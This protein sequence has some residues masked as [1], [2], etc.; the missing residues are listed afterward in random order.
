MRFNNNVKSV[1]TKLTHK[2]VS[3]NCIEYKKKSLHIMLCYVIY[4]LIIH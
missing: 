4:N 1:L 2:N 3:F